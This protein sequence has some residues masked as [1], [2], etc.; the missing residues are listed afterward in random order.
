MLDSHVFLPRDPKWVFVSIS[1]G[2]TPALIIQRFFPL[3]V[4]YRRC[5]LSKVEPRV[6]VELVVRYLEG[7]FGEAALGG[8]T[9]Y[10][11]GGHVML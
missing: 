5:S 10:P 9:R 8:W 7:A 11:T 3:Q 2:E 1:V 4:G 6:R